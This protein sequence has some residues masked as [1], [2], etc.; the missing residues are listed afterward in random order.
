VKVVDRTKLNAEDDDALKEEVAILRKMN[1]KHIVK[2]YDFFEEPKKY[3]IVLEIC[4]GGELFD[5]IVQK[6]RRPRPCLLFITDS[7]C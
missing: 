3:F 7:G 4:E 1:H 5:R 6:V 2:L